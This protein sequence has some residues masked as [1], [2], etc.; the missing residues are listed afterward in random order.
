MPNVLLTS[1]VGCSCWRACAVHY[2][3][4]RPFRTIIQMTAKGSPRAF[5]KSRGA[6]LSFDFQRK[7]TRSAQ[8]SIFRKRALAIVGCRYA[9]G[10]KRK[11]YSAGEWH[12]WQ[13]QRWGGRVHVS[14]Q[15][16]VNAFLKLGRRRYTH[17]VYIQRVFRFK[18][19]VRS[20]WLYY[21]CTR[22]HTYIKRTRLYVY[23]T[24]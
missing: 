12:R 11:Y 19:S 5:Y 17:M 20:R 10:S 16:E 2:N 4:R 9:T 21:Y 8:Y 15:K 23:T 14:P 3:V 1:S 13:R 18:I 6:R 7:K 24:R 22:I